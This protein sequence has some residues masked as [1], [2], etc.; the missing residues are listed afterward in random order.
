VKCKSDLHLGQLVAARERC[1]E[2][3][4]VDGIVQTNIIA[5]VKP[6]DG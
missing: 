1:Q 5:V 4:S 3:T 2:F 6:K